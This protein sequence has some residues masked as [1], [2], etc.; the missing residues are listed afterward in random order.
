MKKTDIRNPFYEDIRKNGIVVDVQSDDDSEQLPSKP[1]YERIA[2]AGG[3]HTPGRPRRGEV[4]EPTAVRSIRLPVE[5]WKLVE[6]QA[7][8]EQISLN[9]A[10]RQAARIWLMS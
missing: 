2:A 4:R 10:M 6:A 1:Y 9:A 3:L 7:K 8:R 5:L